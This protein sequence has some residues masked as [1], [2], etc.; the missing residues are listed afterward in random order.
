MKG[1]CKE[2][3]EV[4]F[5]LFVVCPF[6]R[7][8]STCPVR[9]IRSEPLEDRFCMLQKMTKSEIDSY[10]TYHNECTKLRKEQCSC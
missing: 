7:A 1:S 8:R 9:E 10:L 4:L 6:G 3:M 2:G 5:E